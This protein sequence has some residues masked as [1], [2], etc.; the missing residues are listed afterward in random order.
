MK[1]KELTFKLSPTLCLESGPVCLPCSVLALPFRAVFMCSS[2]MHSLKQHALIL[3]VVP[4]PQKPLQKC[5][6]LYIFPVLVVQ[7]RELS[8][9][10]YK[11]VTIM[12]KEEWSELVGKHG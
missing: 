9:K 5:Q 10:V 2:C 11:C 1:K 8:V 7:L 4:E 6:W 3:S 12:I